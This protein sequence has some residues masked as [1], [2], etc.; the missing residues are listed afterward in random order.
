MLPP[1]PEPVALY[2]VTPA[3]GSSCSVR[4][5]S[6]IIAAVGLGLVLAT[7]GGGL[8]HA[9]HYGSPGYRFIIAFAQPP[10]KRVV[11][12]T[13]LTDTPYGPA[14]ARRTIWSGGNAD[15]LVD[16][17]T[18]PVPPTRVDGLLRSYLPTST[19]GRIVTR[20]GFP[21]AIESVPCFT[22]AGSCPGNIA[23]LV[24]LT[25]TTVY[26]VH[27]GSDAATDQAIISSFRLVSS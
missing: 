13:T 18:T 15:V 23:E 10:T 8:P 17:L 20:F 3:G 5:A 16:Q 25:G 12:V 19:G 21:A 22:P 7:C 2:R 6:E 11:A 1:A 9:G 27:V 26:E 24:I 14:I 4:R